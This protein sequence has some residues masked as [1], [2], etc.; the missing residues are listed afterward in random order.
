[1]QAIFFRDFR[2]MEITAESVG[3]WI[4]AGL[5]LAIY[6]FL[7]KDNPLFKF[8]EHLYVGV[9]VGYGLCIAWFQSLWPD[10]VKPIMK[11]V[12]QDLGLQFTSAAK[13]LELHKPLSNHE[14]YSLLIPAALGLM[15]LTKLNP[16]FSW[17]SRWAFAFIVG[18]GAGMAIPLVTSANIFKQIIPTIMFPADA[19]VLTTINYFLILIGVLC[20]LLYFFFSIEHKGIIGGASK[21][22]IYFMMISFG[23]AFGYTVMARVSLAIER[24]DVL[25]EASSAKNYYATFVCLGIVVLFLVLYEITIKRK[26]AEESKN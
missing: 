25:I 15:I 17:P 19:S 10:C 24:A 3:I 13:Y 9:S 4:A 16:R 12:A 18:A 6:S 23:A 26:P 2:K 11:L 14:N 7:Y 1:M 22:G 5:T 21:V 20:V 8:A